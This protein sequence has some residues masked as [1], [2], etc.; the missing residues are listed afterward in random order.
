MCAPTPPNQSPLRPQAVA[1][2]TTPPITST[3]PPKRPPP[4][5]AQV[6]SAAHAHAALAAAQVNFDRV[7][8]QLAV[9][10]LVSN[11][12]NSSAQQR[13]PPP[14]YIEATSPPT[15]QI[16]HQNVDSNNVSTTT[17]ALLNRNRKSAA[18]KKGLPSHPSN[19][20]R[21]V[22]EITIITGNSN[23]CPLSVNHL[24]GATHFW[25]TS[26]LKML[27]CSFLKAQ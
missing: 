20:D 19:D 6:V 21:P 8:A 26:F 15:A 24:T 22:R 10:A 7:R 18:S 5:D 4:V 11:A 23:Y 2:P 12:S 14:S 16:S 3:T 25:E 13:A 1:R 17:P 9:A 27:I